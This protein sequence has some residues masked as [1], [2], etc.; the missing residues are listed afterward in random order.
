MKKQRY[1]IISLEKEKVFDNIPYSSMIKRLNKLRIQVNCLNI[2][3]VIYEKPTA[4]VIVKQERLK[5]F[6]L[7]WGT[8]QTSPVLL[9]VFNIVLEVTA[10]AIR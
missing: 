8:R 10:R 9:L 4:N 3:K 5:G 1:V 7:R 2:I 6:S